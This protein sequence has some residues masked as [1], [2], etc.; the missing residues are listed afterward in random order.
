[1]LLLW[2]WK[3]TN[4]TDAFLPIYL[5]EYV[6]VNTK[7]PLYCCSNAYKPEHPCVYAV[8][9]TCYNRG[10]EAQNRTRRVIDKDRDRSVCNH[11][12]LI[13]ENNTSY[14]ADSYLTNCEKQGRNIPLKC[15]TCGRYI[16]V[17]MSEKKR[18]QN[19]KNI[20]SVLV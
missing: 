6:I 9:A 15:S 3:W 20:K 14:F 1:M 17:T 4:I 19:E 7:F 8:C 5:T 10:E 16:T 11:T 18:N 13:V 2:G 12:N